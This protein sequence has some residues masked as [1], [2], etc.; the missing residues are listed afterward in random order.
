MAFVI[1]LSM[2]GP[3]LGA[4]AR[5][6]PIATTSVFLYFHIYNYVDYETIR[7]EDQKSLGALI[8]AAMHMTNVSW[9]NELADKYSASLSHFHD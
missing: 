3:I 8:A 4:R 9:M 5:V 1:S 6:L 7:F 2:I